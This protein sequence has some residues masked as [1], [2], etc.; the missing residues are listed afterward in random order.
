MSDTASKDD[1][2]DEL[3]DGVDSFEDLCE[4]YVYQR[5]TIADLQRDRNKLESRVQNLM[6]GQEVDVKELRTRLDDAKMLL[7]RGE[8]ARAM[9][10]LEAMEEVL[11]G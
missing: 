8:L 1:L 2:E 7:E 10:H 11:D 9:D 4:V 5:N 3:P 6:M